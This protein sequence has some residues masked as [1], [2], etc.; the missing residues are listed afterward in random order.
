MAKGQKSS[1]SSGTRKKNARKAAA[2][3]AAGSPSSQPSSSL[4]PPTAKPPKNTKYTKR[5]LKEARKREKVYIPPVKPAPPQLDPLD[6]MGLARTLPPD[7]VIVLRSLG[8]KDVVTKTKAIEE[9]SKW[10]DEAAKEQ[11]GM[12]D[13]DYVNGERTSAMVEML[14]VWVH[15]VPVLFTHPARR[16]R[17][18][19][20]SLQVSL[21]HL[22]PTRSA[23]VHWAQDRASQAELDTVLGTWAILVHDV[24]RG[25]ARVGERA[26]T[27]FVGGPPNPTSASRLP[28]L[29]LTQP[30]LISLLDFA[31]NAALD[32][33]ALHAALNPV[34]VP[35]VPPVI[36][37]GSGK[38][39]QGKKGVPPGQGKG[40]PTHGKKG[41]QPVLPAK[42]SGRYI[43]P[44]TPEPH[45]HASPRSE[46]P[47]P[48][49]TPGEESEPDRN[50]RLRASALGIVRWLIADNHLPGLSSPSSPADT[51]LASLLRPLSPLLSSPEFWSSLH[52]GPVCPYAFLSDGSENMEKPPVV[53]GCFGHSQPQEGAVLS[54]PAFR[55][56]L[57]YLELG[58]AGV[59]VEGYPLVLVVVAGIP[60]T[61]VTP[62]Y[63]QILPRSLASPPLTQLLDALWAP[64]YARLLPE[65]RAATAWLRA[66]LECLVFVVRRAC[67]VGSVSESSSSENEDQPKAEAEA[68][69]VATESAEERQ[70]ARSLLTAHFTTLL[71]A[72]SSRTLRIDAVEVAHVIADALGRLSKIGEDLFGVA[73]DVIAGGLSR[74]EEQSPGLAPAFLHVFSTSFAPGT[75]AGQRTQVLVKAYVENVMQNAEAALHETSEPENVQDK[76]GR[77]I[78][79]LDTFG[80]R[81]FEDEEFTSVSTC[82]LCFI[83]T[84]PLTDFWLHRPN[85]LVLLRCFPSA[86][87][88]YLKHRSESGNEEGMVKN[89]TFWT[90]LLTSI[91][92]ASAPMEQIG[93][94]TSLLRPLLSAAREGSLPT[95]LHGASESMDILLF[96]LLDYVL[97][98]RPEGVAEALLCDTLSIYSYFLSSDGISAIMNA[99]SQ[100]ISKFAERALQVAGVPHTGAI[101]SDDQSATSVDLELKLVRRLV[102]AGYH[103]VGERGVELY[104]GIALLAFIVPSVGEDGGDGVEGAEDARRI[105]GTLI[106]KETNQEGPEEIR[107]VV[108]AI[109]K[110]R[111]RNSVMDSRILMRPEH[112]IYALLCRIP[113]LSVDILQ[114]ILPSRSELDILLDDLST[115]PVS[116]SMAL[117][118]CTIPTTSAT[119][120]AGNVPIVDPGDALVLSLH[121]Y[122][123]A[124][125]ALLAYLSSVRTEARAH[126]WALRHVIA[127][128]VYIAEYVHVG[129]QRSAVFGGTLDVRSGRDPVAEARRQIAKDLERKV[130]GLTTY[131]LSRVEEGIHVQAVGAL[132]QND[133]GGPSIEEGSLAAFVVEVVRKSIQSDSTR[134]ALVLRTTLQHLFADVTRDEADLWLTLARRLERTASQTSIVILA[135]ITA[136]APEPPKLERYRN[137]LAAALL[138]IKPADSDTTGLKYLRL[139]CASAPDPDSDVVFLPQQRA[140]NVMRACQTWIAEGDEDASEDL[141]SAMTLVFR[142]IA[143]ILQNVSGSHWEFIWD[144]IENNLEVC[145]LEESDTLATLGR[146]LQLVI[147]IEDLVA[148]NKSLRE[149]WEKRREIILNLVKSVVVVDMRGMPYSDPRALCRELAMTIVQ[150]MPSSKMDEKTL[151]TMCHLLTDY[152]P[153][154]QKMSYQLLQRAAHKLTEHFVIEAGVDT[155][156]VINPELPGELVAIL[157]QTLSTGDAPSSQDAPTSADLEVSGYLL[158]WMVTFD[159]FA[160]ASLKVRAGYFNHM[161]NLE[162]ISQYFIPNIFGI[163]GLLTGGRKT[164]KLGMWAVDEFYLDTY[165]PANPLSLRLLAAHLYHRALLTVSPLI[166]SWISDCMDKQLLTRVIDYTSSHLSPGIIRAEL[167]QVRQPDV[168]SELST[169]EN[170][171]IKAS[172]A[173]NEVTAS[174]TVDEQALEL[175][176]RMPNDWPLHRF[177]VRDT[178]MVLLHSQRD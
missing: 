136:Y 56:F 108:S 159:L 149:G 64:L 47:A 16:I 4:A 34:A 38:G 50:G 96:Q 115:S 141:D 44:P 76:V 29:A 24:D 49:D 174:Y 58:C 39:A 70:E 166:R 145:S 176:I 154:V 103:I 10:V 85:C 94:V 18:L 123:R 77:L 52:P 140:V 62:M 156:G 126:L 54:S 167:A 14:P 82:S 51:S 20:A 69:G 116:S 26:F 36:H 128:G 130:H 99:L 78:N 7:L 93:S 61:S 57:S 129:D 37:I 45:S 66:L 122:G 157:Q 74:S 165:E 68:S 81:F 27:D 84:N 2:A 1:A 30:I 121:P 5:E 146:T 95:C 28:C 105:W 35:V 33:A 148:T 40:I 114:D 106:A 42:K 124:V 158:A 23:L 32:P 19:A 79:I 152:S 107:Q 104:V 92:S 98:H 102:D 172:L 132:L 88:S 177:E 75:F 41:G 161:R 144:I 150:D 155:E 137:E 90:D 120:D 9:L 134:D 118:D 72:L 138:G 3:A 22:P 101:D 89:Q 113:G 109:L 86:V 60:E 151:T 6:T 135:S 55:D 31:H 164:F 53:E 160:G 97:T 127:F 46:S 119:D 147:T 169:A 142:H 168:A 71:D 13:G 63:I 110:E 175:S 87:I 8:K 48:S 11:S 178:K 117:I 100:S 12:V 171:T 170:L 21:I 83:I 25:V 43:P 59:A 153:D 17:L 173:L 162:I 131:L 80:Q 111:L 65:R 15:R 143:P 73:F 112:V 163:L 91:A 133:I 125:T 67:N 139:L